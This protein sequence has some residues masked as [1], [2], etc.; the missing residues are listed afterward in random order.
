MF[1]AKDPR[2][3]PYARSRGVHDGTFLCGHRTAGRQGQT[4]RHLR[5][6]FHRNRCLQGMQHGRR[7]AA[8][9]Q[10][11]ETRRSS[12]GQGILQSTPMP[13]F[14]VDRFGHMHP[15]ACGAQTCLQSVAVTAGLP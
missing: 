3:A 4:Q 14:S 8:Q 12:Q 7:C 10:D 6:A 15:T 1:Q 5:L 11:F 9:I 2:Q 13:L